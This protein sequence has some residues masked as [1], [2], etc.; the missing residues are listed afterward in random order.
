LIQF[1]PTGI[2]EISIYSGQLN[3]E[4]AKEKIKLF[5]DSFPE[6]P[7][8]FFK[9]L[10]Y[11]IEKN[12]FSDKRLEDAIDFVIFNCKYPK[13][14]IADIIQFDQRFKIYSFQKIQE[15]VFAGAIQS[16]YM[17]VDIRQEKPGWIEKINFQKSGLKLWKIK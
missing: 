2:N 5:Q 12:K 1:S 3:P 10:L 15:M 17:K 6:L 11:A 9:V 4:F 14:T 13:P 8:P 7:P 16:D